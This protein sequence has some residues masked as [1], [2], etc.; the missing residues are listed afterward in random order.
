[1]KDPVEC[2]WNGIEWI[3][4]R[5][6]EGFIGSGKESADAYD[7]LDRQEKEWKDEQHNRQRWGHR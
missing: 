2:F 7:D 4:Y 3:A 6:P 5:D 1:M